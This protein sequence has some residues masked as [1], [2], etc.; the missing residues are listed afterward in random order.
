MVLTGIVGIYSWRHRSVPGATGLAFMMFFGSLKLI[1]TTLGLTAEELPPKLFWFQIE[2]FCLLPSTIAGL[3]F[4]LEYAGLDTWLNRRSLALLS[5]P[6]LL[7]IPLTF[8]N[9]AHHLIWTHMWLDGR[10]HYNPG[11]FVYPLWGYGLLLGVATIVIFIWLFIRSPLSRWPVGLILLNL[12]ISRILFYL[13]EAGLNPFKPLELADMAVMVICPV[14]FLAL[15]H[16]R[17]FEVVPV[18]RNRVIE[19]MRDGMLVLDART[20][21]ADLNGAAQQL[22]G[23]ARSKVIGREATQVFL[24]YPKLRE[25][26]RSPATVQEEIFVGSHSYRVHISRL[27]NRRGYELGKLILFY[28]ISEEKRTQKQLHDHQQKLTMLEE[29]EWLARE[30]HDGVGQALAAA[31]LHSKTVSELFARRQVVGVE[32]SLDQLAK[33]I[34]EGKA[35][36]GD[37]L[38]GVRTWSSKDPFFAGLRRYV[39]NYNQEAG[40]RTELIIAPEIER[41]PLGGIIETQLQRIIQEGLTNIKRH[42]SAHSARVVFAVDRDQVEVLIEDDGRGFDPVGLNGH[43][44]FGLRAMAGRAE[45]VGG[46]LEVNSAPGKGTQVIIRVPW[47]KEGSHED[48]VSG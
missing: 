43:E 48:V 19:Q 13:N 3:A 21:V 37:Y 24:N 16:F 32:T 5:I 22:L 31:D 36:V 44:G 42:A 30:L 25:L 17:M 26:L 27:T 9:N 45:A 15:F 2:R 7:L 8:T 1:A 6:A 4:A 35:H 29:R 34:K 12:F 46:H 39:T 33:A 10:I 11:N 41:N 23:V 28:D 20:R 47:G 14:Y 18:A 40:V 38:F